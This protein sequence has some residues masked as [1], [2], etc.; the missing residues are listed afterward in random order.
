MAEHTYD[1]VVVGAGLHGL[2]S[3]LYLARAGQRVVT[4]ERAWSGRHASGASAAG[5][6]TLGRGLVELA[7]S[8]EA[9]RLWNDIRALVG[10]DCGYHR[11]GQVR[12]AENEA[13][14]EKLEQRAVLTRSFGYTHEELIDR[15]ALRRLVPR[16]SHH[17]MGALWVR[18]DGAADPHRTLQAFRRAA[19]AA[20]VVIRENCGVDAIARQSEGYA[21]SAGGETFRAP[22]IVN[23]AGAWAGRI[24]AM[25]GDDIPLRTKASMMI[26]TERV[27]PV[28]APVLGVAGR[29]LSFKQSDQGTL[30][31]GGGRQ[32]VPDIDAETATVRLEEVAHSAR[33]V[34][35]LFPSVKDL[36]IVRVWA[37][38]EAATEDGEPVIGASPNAPGV[39]HVFGFTGHGFQLVP[40]TGAIIADV[41]VHG[42]TGRDIAGL[43]AT[44]LLRP[45]GKVS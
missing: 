42:Q 21:V 18:D 34:C 33:T 19:E 30:L 16:L 24:A 5:V 41:V 20:G 29:P 28:L 1:A 3:A 14:M 15:N 26:V 17:C 6:R 32:G 12:I 35:E 25:V 43:Q 11:N 44:R 45:S 10:D 4:L 7:I 9:Q 31:I 38:L 36:R 22:V 40:V 8:L 13:D 37:G 2:S 27:A 23:C 39:F